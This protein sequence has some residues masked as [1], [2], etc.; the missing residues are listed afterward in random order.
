MLATKSRLRV[1]SMYSKSIEVW[2]LGKVSCGFQA[3]NSALSRLTPVTLYI[4]LRK[5][6][7]KTW[8]FII[9]L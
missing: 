1:M 2:L 6:L 5:L 3:P 7:I 8:L 4:I 9:I